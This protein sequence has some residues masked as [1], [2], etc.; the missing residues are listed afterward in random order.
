MLVG[1]ENE[2][3]GIASVLAHTQPLFLFALAVPFLNDKVI[4]SRVLGGLFGFVG[5]VVLSFR[6]LGLFSLESTIVLLVG[7][8]L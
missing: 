6:G 8:L 1:L 3:S 4:S 5:I 2:G 7:A